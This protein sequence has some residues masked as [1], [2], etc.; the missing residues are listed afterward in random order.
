MYQRANKRKP[1]NRHP[2]PLTVLPDRAADVPLVVIVIAILLPTCTPAT[3]P[4]SVPDLEVAIL[5]AAVA[6][7]LG[8]ISLNNDTPETHSTVPEYFRFLV[9]AGDWCAVGIYPRTDHDLG[10]DDNEDLGSVYAWSSEYGTTRDFIVASGHL[11]GDDEHYA[12]VS[13]DSP[14]TYT[15][16]AEWEP[17]DLAAGS[18]YADVIGTGEV[19]Q[20][21]QAYLSAGVEYEVGVDIDSGS[22]D[23]GLFVYAPSRM[24]GARTTY[25][26]NSAAGGAGT[27]ESIVFVAP[28][29][30]A[31]GIVIVNDNNGSADYTVTVDEVTCW[32]HLATAE[33]GRV[34]AE[35]T[36]H[37]LPWQG[38]FVCGSTVQL[39]A[40]PVDC[41]EFDQWS[42]AL[43]GSTNPTS[44]VMSD[45][46][47]VTVH[48]V[49][50]TAAEIT[51][52]EAAIAQP[53]GCGYT[54]IAD[55]YVE[56]R[57]CGIDGLRVCFD[58]SMDTTAADP[59][60]ISI[61]GEAGGDLSHLVSGI[62]W[63]GDACMLVNL[64]AP[65]PDQDVYT[66]AAGI[67]LTSA[68]G[69]SLGGDRDVAFSVLAGDVSGDGIVD[70]GDLIQARVR[71]GQTPTTACRCDVNCNGVVDN[72][73][74]IAIRVRR[75]NA[76]P[77]KPKP[78]AG[79]TQKGGQT[80]M[81][82]S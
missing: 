43:S 31:Y 46:S 63:D 24:V 9:R 60:M 68:S 18:G 35:G 64:S 8:G 65:L 5:A 28:E 69:C 47:D 6:G 15:I 3:P 4:R 7:P 50:L 29:S 70:N 81:P 40:V 67:E 49:P 41:G 30:G 82:L 45:D 20:V 1:D 73:D 75:G 80:R 72:S 16:E 26:W 74:L 42:G 52:W 57:M 78:R 21:Y 39:E 54:E 23:L 38:E 32:L 76:P 79:P 71:R 36:L 33:Q 58:H 62:D 37:D 17:E 11:W 13:Y 48:F 12:T 44:I 34:W 77:S 51:S 22:A 53:A 10:A 55:G 56:P 14:S 61:I 19:L 59:G 2:L 25:D 27:D 66:I